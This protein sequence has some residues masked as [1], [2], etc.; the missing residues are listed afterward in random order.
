MVEAIFDV[1]ARLKS[2]GVTILL[3]EQN[4]FMALEMADRAHV[5][6]QGRIA[7]SGTGAE[8]AGNDEV[9]R[10]YLGVGA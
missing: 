8:L 4:A 6:E 5:L 7:I 1:I 2:S 3:I 10:V 9:R